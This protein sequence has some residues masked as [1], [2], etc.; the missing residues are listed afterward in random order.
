M[1]V[2]NDPRE[3]QSLCLNWR[4]GQ[5]RTALVPTMGYFHAGHI[6]LMRWS[7]D[8]ADK[9]LVSLFVNPTQFGPNEDLASYPRD[10]ERD[11]A[12]AEEAG[13]DVLFAPE[14]EAMYAKDHTT[15]VEL[16]SLSATLCG[17]SRPGH[18]SGVATVV[19]K[20]LMLALPS[21]AVFGQKDW[22]QLAI[23]RRLVRDLDIPVQ[24]E[25]RPIVREPD[26]LAMSSRNVYLGREERF[27]APN[28]HKGLTLAAELVQEGTRDV[29]T[30]GCRIR[31]FFHQTMPLARPDYIEFVNPQTLQ[32]AAAIDDA[33][34]LAVVMAFG[35][36]RLIDNTLL[37]PEKPSSRV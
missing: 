6:S 9:V 24:V 1:R 13:A 25:G 15:R 12:M 14:P 30:L 7:R 37:Q 19:T 23:I 28:I 3:F 26:G 21:V 11:R 33:V 36:A 27:Q 10:F 35:K 5:I 2:V 4:F 31:D 22:Q 32:P 29:Q 20:L 16:A 8:N 34:L 18:F 17:R